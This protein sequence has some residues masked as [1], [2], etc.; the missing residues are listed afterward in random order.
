[1]TPLSGGSVLAVRSLGFILLFGVSAFIL[2]GL[3]LAWWRASPPPKLPDGPT[4]IL[5]MREVAR[6]ETLDVTE[7][8]KVSFAPDPPPA[9]SFWK[10]V[11]AWAKFNVNPSHGKAIVFAHLH[12][13]L[14]LAHL[15]AQHLRIR[16]AAVE[17]VLPPLETRVELLPGELEVIDS[18]LS[19]AETAQLLQLAKDA[20]EHE[21]Q[22]DPTLQSRAQKSA[23]R[24]LRGLL[25]TLGFREVRFV[26]Q[27]PAES[28]AG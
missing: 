25:V 2:G 23:E 26:P 17:L 27:L 22:A 21:A 11:K 4:V 6:L 28:G 15:D 19:S 14:S 18:N 12:V 13:G 3:A 1:M 7:Y 10:E 20:F 16:G 9:S 8:K 5:K 24:A